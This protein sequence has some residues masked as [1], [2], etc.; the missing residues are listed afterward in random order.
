MIPVAALSSLWTSPSHVVFPYPV[1]MIAARSEILALC[2]PRHTTGN[3][4][5]LRK[6]A[7]TL[8]VVV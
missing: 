1:A 8:P 3:P 4:N 6:P 7:D 5:H 2:Q